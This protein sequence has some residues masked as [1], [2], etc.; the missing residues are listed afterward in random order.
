MFRR[1]YISLES[2]L[3]EESVI[4]QVPSRLTVVTT[5]KSKLFKTP[6]G[7]IEFT[8]TSRNPEDL[9]PRT[10]YDSQRRAFLASPFL[11]YEDLK[12]VRRNL[13]LIDYDELEDAQ[14]NWE[15]F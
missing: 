9:V 7:M 6:F 4:S 12:N 8:H 15:S 5:G 13:D 14:S 2:R 11:A 1:D 3:S 10:R